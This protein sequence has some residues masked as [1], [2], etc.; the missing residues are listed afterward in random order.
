[1]KRRTA[2]YDVFFDGLYVKILAGALHE[3]RAEEEARIVRKLLHLRKGQRVLDVPSGLGRITLPLARMGLQMTGVDLTGAY[4]R[5]ARRRA[6]KEGLDVRFIQ[7]D[8]R[9]IDFEGEFDAAFNWF[10][11][12][13]YFSETDNLAF[14]KRVFAALRPG[15]RFLVEGINKSWLLRHFRPGAEE[16]VAGV[17]IRRRARWEARTNRVRDTWTLSRDGMTERCRISIRIYNGTEMRRLLR[18]AGFG[19][20]ELYGR[21]PVRRFTRHSRRLIAVARRPR[22]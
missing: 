1:M 20:I 21:P 2:W 6:G 14:A 3:G 12:F 19:E 5:R 17:T 15:G 7:S 11:S 13:G 22:K 8:M 18:A 10:G 9:E 4:V 16:S